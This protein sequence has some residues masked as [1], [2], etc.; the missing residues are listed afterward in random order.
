MFYGTWFDQ[1]PLMT[2]TPRGCSLSPSSWLDQGVMT[3]FRR[4]GVD[5]ER[6]PWGAYEMAG[7]DNIC[8]RRHSAPSELLMSMLP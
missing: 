1:N 7:Q 2:G 4:K 8:Y 5:T 3:H 6:T